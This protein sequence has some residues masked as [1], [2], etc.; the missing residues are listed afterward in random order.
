MKMEN[1]KL[2]ASLMMMLMMMMIMMVT[3]KVKA[4]H[5]KLKQEFSLEVKT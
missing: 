1:H 2:A 5:E 3:N 4:D